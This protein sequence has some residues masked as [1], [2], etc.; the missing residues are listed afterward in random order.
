MPF[1]ANPDGLPSFRLKTGAER[2]YSGFANNPRKSP[3]FSCFLL[4]FL[5]FY[6]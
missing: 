1:H 3:G 2:R 5:C 4:E 6:D